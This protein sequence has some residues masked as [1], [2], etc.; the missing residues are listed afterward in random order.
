MSLQPNTATDGDY[1]GFDEQA[2]RDEYRRLA[3][4]Y[5]SSRALE[6]IIQEAREELAQ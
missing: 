4:L 5:G 6:M 3:G 2:R 1:A